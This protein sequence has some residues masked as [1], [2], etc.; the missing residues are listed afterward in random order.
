M[1]Q[2]IH[3]RLL[4]GFCRLGRHLP[5]LR[6]DVRVERIAAKNRRRRHHPVHHVRVPAGDK[7]RHARTQRVA[8]DVGLAELEVGDQRRDV[9]GHQGGIQRAVADQ[10]SA[11]VA[12]Q[13]HRNHLPPFGQP[14]KV[15]AVHLDGTQP[16]VEQ[17]QRLAGAMN[18]IVEVH[19]VDIGVAALGLVPA[20]PAAPGPGVGLAPKHRGNEQRTQ[21]QGGN[22]SASC[23]FCQSESHCRVRLRVGLP[24]QGHDERGRANSTI[25]ATAVSADFAVAVSVPS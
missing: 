17:D 1:V 14:G 23:V 16:A 8:H 11:A 21:S 25:Q 22:D 13:V 10:G 20:R 3:R 15:G 9:V 7:D 5:L 12:V 18:L 6:K 19:A 24:L 2:L 4:H